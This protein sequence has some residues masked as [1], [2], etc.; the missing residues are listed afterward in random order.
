MH[1]FLFGVS[2]TSKATLLAASLLMDRN[3]TVRIFLKEFTETRLQASTT[4]I[5]DRREGT[6]DSDGSARESTPVLYFA[7]YEDV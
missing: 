7:V 3:A 4:R 2:F 1:D 6:D 5:L